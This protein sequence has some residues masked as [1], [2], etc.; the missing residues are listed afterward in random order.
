[1]NSK[2]FWYILMAG[3]IGL[4]VVV[5]LAAILVPSVSMIAWIV[6]IALAAVHVLEF[7]LVSKKI[8]DKKGISGS[9]AFIK[10]ILFGFTWWLAL[11]NGIIEK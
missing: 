7:P 5:L 9:T 11:K 3:S 1:M 10:T 6:F 8:S 4:W 2:G